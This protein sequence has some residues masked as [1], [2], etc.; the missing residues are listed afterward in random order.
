MTI[1]SAFPA[2]IIPLI[3]N[4]LPPD[5]PHQYAR[6]VLAVRWRKTGLPVPGIMDVGNVLVERL[7]LARPPS[8]PNVAGADNRRIEERKKCALREID[9]TFPLLPG[10]S[11][12]EDLFTYLAEPWEQS[13][14]GTVVLRRQTNRATLLFLI[15]NARFD[16][17][18]WVLELTQPAPLVDIVVHAEAAKPVRLMADTPI[19]KSIAADLAK[20]LAE[21]M[22][23]EAI[24]GPI[25][26]LAGGVIAGGL[27]GAIVNGVF[28]LLF[29]D[30]GDS[31]FD[32]YFKGLEK[33]VCYELSQ[34]VI[35]Q[36]S[37]TLTSLKNELE[38]VYG[39]A[40]L[41][42]DL[43]DKEDR[44]FLFNQLRQYESTF[45]IGAGGMLGTLQQKNYRLVGFPVFLL[46]AG[47]HL[48]ILQEM[49][50]VDP[51]NKAPDF[52]PLQSSYGMPKTG[53]VARFAKLYADFAEATW[54]LIVADRKSHI[55][56]QT[57]VQPVFRHSVHFGYYVDDL[58]NDDRRGEIKFEQENDKN[59]NYHY[60][61]GHG[62]D[63]VK[64]GMENYIAARMKE[65]GD[66][67]QERE[68]IMSSWRM[69]I[70]A[71]LNIK[72]A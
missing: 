20:K 36:V 43:R 47:L 50:N 8:Q 41:S 9:G 6:E 38:N 49:A 51:S 7:P 23:K 53:S 5:D 16:P 22:A 45:F 35:D 55:T 21:Q 10:E 37:G 70:D 26:Q 34:S 63:D 48:A 29:P 30:K 31:V 52:D 68:G 69:L 33:I 61:P 57:R 27:A 2:Q 39:P 65:L 1:S 62:P 54:P 3:A 44:N 42:H 14:A 46:G 59:L 71:P 67:I 11:V 19:A 58:I 56:Y 28:S 15:A 64:K 25:G 66:G 40:R 72:A 24:T 60:T 12:T 4:V 13:P 32:L 18:S 17:D